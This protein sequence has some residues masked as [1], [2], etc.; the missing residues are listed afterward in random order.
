MDASTFQKRWSFG[1]LKKASRA[2]LEQLQLPVE[3]KSFLAE[4]GLPVHGPLELTF[5]VSLQVT[6]AGLIRIGSDSATEMCIDPGRQG[7]VVSVDPEGKLP[8]RFVNSSAMQLAEFIL[9][10]RESAEA[11]KDLADDEEVQ[12]LSEDVI[13][14]W[15]NL[16]PEA[17]S[18]RENWWAV[19]AEQMEAGLL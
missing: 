15:R 8:T 5:D 17:F 10:Y 13:R 4:G 1:P 6:K 16:D 2:A 9:L 18:D 19:V 3:A 7:A 14:A 11:A 12:R